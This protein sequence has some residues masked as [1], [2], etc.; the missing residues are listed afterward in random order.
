M[1][2]EYLVW[3]S[4]AWSG[5]GHFSVAGG[6]EEGSKI[7]CELE[8]VQQSCSASSE[9]T[10]AFS[11]QGNWG[12]NEGSW[13]VCNHLHQAPQGSR[14]TWGHSPG[15]FLLLSPQGPNQDKHLLGLSTIQTG[16][17]PSPAKEGL[18]TKG[19]PLHTVSLIVSLRSKCLE[20]ARLWWLRW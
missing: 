13:H 15:L 5:N 11:R 3:I 1:K 17:E 16:R 10:N 7:R 12:T 18:W 20:H 9:R 4:P 14:N 6:R 19:C 2:T 8:K